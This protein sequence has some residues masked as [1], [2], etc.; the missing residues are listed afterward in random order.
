MPVSPVTS[1]YEHGGKQCMTV[2]ALPLHK[3]SASASGDLMMLRLSLYRYRRGD[4]EARPEAGPFPP[5]TTNFGARV[6]RQ[7]C[8]ILRAGTTSLPLST[9]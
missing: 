2:L 4:W 1:E 7:R 6:A 5:Y 8:P 9:P 3:K